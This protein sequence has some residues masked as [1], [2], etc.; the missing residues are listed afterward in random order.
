MRLART[1]T[2]V[3]LAMLA[4]SLVA[5]TPGGERIG[6]GDLP[7][8]AV[9][10]TRVAGPDRVLTA[11]ALARTAFERAEVAVLARAGDFPDALTA[12]YLA[13]QH[14]APVLL[15]RRDRMHPTILDTLEDLDVQRVVILGGVAAV[16]AGIEQRLRRDWA[17]TRIQ[18]SD[19]FAT[20]AAVARA[21]GSIGGAPHQGGGGGE[22]TTAILGTGL[23]FP[24]VLAAGP[25]AYAGGHPV[26]LAA[27]DTLPAPAEAAIR[28]LGVEQVVIVGGPQAVGDTVVDRLRE[29]GVVVTR[30]AGPTRTATA[31][32]VADLTRRLL[33]WGHDRISLAR[34]DDFADALALAPHAAGARSVVALTPTPFTIGA[35][36]FEQIQAGCGLAATVVLAGGA[37]AL[38]ADAAREASLASVCADQAVPMSG[39]LE[40][41]DADPEASGAAHLWVDGSVCYALTVEGAAPA[42]SAAIH[43]ATP[44]AA[45]PVA[46]VLRTPGAG[47]FSA[48]CLRDA[49]V[50]PDVVPDGTTEVLA[51]RLRFDRVGYYINVP[52]T[53]QPGGAVR[54]NVGDLAFQVR[55]SGA[56]EIDP[57]AGTFVEDPAAGTAAAELRRI[58]DDRLCSFLDVEGV[59]S[60]VTAAHVHRGHVDENGPVV[61]PLAT[62]APRTSLSHLACTTVDPALL[63]EIFE[64]RPAAFYVN[65][66]TVDRPA[67]AL[68]SQVG[69]DAQPLLTGAAEVD[70][71]DPDTPRFGQGPAETLGFAR[72]WVGRP[73]GDARTV[74]LDA[75]LLLPDGERLTPPDGAEGSIHVHRGRVDENGEIV[76]GWSQFDGLPSG[77]EATAAGFACT[78][79]PAEAAEAILADPRGLYL[80]AHTQSF[81]AG[82]LRGQLGPELS[83]FATGAEIPGDAGHRTGYAAADVWTGS[84]AN[85]DVVCGSVFNAL[86]DSE[87]DGLSLHRGDRGESGPVIAPLVSG[88]DPAFAAL[89]SCATDADPEAVTRLRNDPAGHYL[90]LDTTGFPEGAMRGQLTPGLEGSSTLPGAQMLGQPSPDRG[91]VATARNPAAD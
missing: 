41:H 87:V 48:G 28:D 12:A 15:T 21:G 16:S 79:A 22:L 20:A 83:T 35:D 88:A 59:P 39:A 54:G 65:V 91:F 69:A 25:L 44:G 19:R 57:D 26:L 68:R 63:D 84:S 64:E 29:L 40:L 75:E 70:D 90:R 49:D 38:T 10:P 56:A 82:A 85:P 1:A 51:G 74:C 33:G 11:I 81:P 34:G 76:F 36:A 7:A 5:A 62:G 58:T 89:F 52:T 18:G 27:G 53:A 17:V 4:M 50:N 80:N 78:T 3:T 55:L 66:H 6:D 86:I 47:G 61:I 31:A 46:A 37:A 2:V 23:A 60:P 42:T 9:A 8:G 77:D 30:V 24:D 13:G 14:D 67:G 73:T 32:A 72:I 43:A 45:G 71:G